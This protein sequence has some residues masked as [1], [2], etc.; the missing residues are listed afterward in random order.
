MEHYER[1]TIAIGKAI[2]KRRNK[3][4]MNQRQLAHYAVVTQATIGFIET[5]KR[6]ASLRSLTGI[7]QALDIPISTLILEAEHLMIMGRDK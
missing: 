3:A 2:K 7:C 6:S 1:L 5:G 4:K